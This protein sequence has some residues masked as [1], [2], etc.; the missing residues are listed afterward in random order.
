MASETILIV[1]DV[2]VNLKVAS[3]IL[4][5]EGYTVHLASNGQ[6][7]LAAVA[8]VH[9][10]LILLDLSLPDIDGLE[11]AR[12][13]KRDPLT[14]GTVILALTAYSPDE[15]AAE[16]KAAGFAG[17]LA[18]P[19]DARAVIKKVVEYLRPQAADPGPSS[20]SRA[21]PENILHNP[22]I[23][24]LRRN[25]LADGA[26][27]CRRM[28]PLLPGSLPPETKQLSHKWI[29]AAGALGCHEIAGLARKLDDM[30]R[31]VTRDPS[32]LLVTLQA[33]LDAFEQ[34]VDT[35][36]PPPVPAA[37][38]PAAPKPAKRNP[39]V[40]I[41]D[42]DPNVRMVIKAVL[43]NGGFD[44]IVA[45]NGVEALRLARSRF[46]SAA[47]LDVNMPGISGFAILAKL[48]E[49]KIP[50]RV[51]LV[52]A[53]QQT[54]DVLQGFKLGA[55][56]YIVK[57]FNPAEVVARLARVLE[58]SIEARGGDSQPDPALAV[59]ALPAG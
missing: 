49:E 40:L 20:A 6:E 26:R 46:P 45:E 50:I 27:Q 13:V 22:E 33:L 17:Y 10:A 3:A 2:P 25:F 36:P 16:V 48:R 1:D 43:E 54:N 11:V 7:A 15:C 35:A 55:D 18:K 38:A 9:P 8:Q 42:D 37:V 52:T 28:L 56:D 30:L 53:R 21:L 19:L 5:N 57:P 31:A 29:G 47:I 12:R 32:A 14:R 34:P 58:R 44:V 24:R 59:S 41:A 51:I 39:D 4:R 23:E